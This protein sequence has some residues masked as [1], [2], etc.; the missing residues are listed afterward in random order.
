MI[1]LIP[2]HC[3]SIYFGDPWLFP[4]TFLPKYL[5]GCISH[6]CI[7]G[8]N[9]SIDVHVLITQSNEWCEFPTYRCLK[10]ASQQ[11]LYFSYFQIPK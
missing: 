10:N 9:H 8:G 4:V 1:V 11:L 3:P 5:T 6:N 7:V 2:D